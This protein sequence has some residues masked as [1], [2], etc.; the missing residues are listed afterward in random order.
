MNTATALRQA[1]TGQV[2]NRP[3]TIFDIISGKAFQVGLTKVVGKYMTADKMA[4]L[5]INAVKKTPRLLE[6]DPLSVTGAMMAS[7][8]LQLEPN[9]VQQQAF[10]IPYKKRVKVGDQWI[11]AY[12]CQFQVGSRG[13][14]TL[15]YRSP[16]IKFLTAE[17]IHENDKFEHQLGTDTFLRYSKSLRNRGELIGSFSYVLFN[18]GA[19]GS[20]LLPLEEIL[21]IRSKSE[22]F[23]TLTRN[24]AEPKDEKARLRAQQQLDETPWVMWEDDMSSKSAIKKHAKQLPLADGGGAM[25]LAAD[26][27]DR[28]DAGTI[29]I[30]AFAD[31]EVAAAVVSD[32]AELP[33]IDHSTGEIFEGG[34]EA[35]GATARQ[36]E[37]VAAKQAQDSSNA[38][39][40][41]EATAAAKKVAGSKPKGDAA[42]GADA[43]DRTYAQIATAIQKAKDRDSAALELDAARG[44]PSDQYDDLVKLFDKQWSE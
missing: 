25:A 41:P 15:A 43:P 3:K 23:R 42:A 38:K 35:F 4:S 8:A 6:C 1:A 10:L 18:S 19:E 44:L 22:T 36:A 32:K 40:K 20:C 30:S 33:V 34:G 14:V 21:K 27:D 31:P 37:T 5:C 11:D 16:V 2:A 9:T 24:L 13:F 29:D 39:A 17:A 28:A 7:A 26:M 12:D